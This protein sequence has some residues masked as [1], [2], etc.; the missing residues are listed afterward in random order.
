MSIITGMTP[1]DCWSIEGCVGVMP[2]REAYDRIATG[3][4]HGHRYV[5]WKPVSVIA[6]P[7]AATDI[8]RLIDM[9]ESHVHM[10]GTQLSAIQDLEKRLQALEKP[11]PLGRG[12]D[13]TRD[14]EYQDHLEKRRQEASD[15]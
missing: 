11:S 15:E 6:P 8:T 1:K 9:V 7:A 10:L 12:V 13:D 4:A 3:V 5:G 2:L 14:S